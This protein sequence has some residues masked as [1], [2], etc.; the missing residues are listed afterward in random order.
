[1][2]YNLTKSSPDFVIVCDTRICPSI[3]NTV[4]EEWGGKCLFNSFSSQARG[5]ALFMKKGNTAQVLDS[6]G[7][8]NGNVL[9]ILINFHGKRILLEGL[10]GPNNDSPNFYSDLAFKKIDDWSPEFSIFAGDYNIAL[11]PTLDT[12]NYLHDNNPNAR[13][14]LLN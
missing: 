5:V 4:R 9:A 8:E 10:Y 3:E 7:D 12:C 1:M 14:E 2:L 13:R 11:N 6:F